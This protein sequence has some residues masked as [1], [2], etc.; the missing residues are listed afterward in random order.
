[1]FLRTEAVLEAHLFDE[2]YFMYPEDIDLTRTIHR[3][4]L[5]I[6]YPAVT[7]VHNHAKGSYH[8]F[9]LLWIHIVN[10]CRYFN[11]WGWFFD[12][13]RKEYNRRLMADV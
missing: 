4:W 3:N 13:E 9:H 7:I 2:R 1:M 12:P 10:M 11:K 8:S 6:Y 5:T